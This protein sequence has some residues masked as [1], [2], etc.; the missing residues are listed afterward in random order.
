[1]NLS[2]LSYVFLAGIIALAIVDQW[3]DGTYAGFWR[4]AA[5]LLALSL[6]YEWAIQRNYRLTIM[7]DTEGMLRLGRKGTVNLHFKNLNRRPLRI[8]YVPLLP[9]AF[10]NSLEPR[11]ILLAPG[12]TVTEVIEI[13]PREL[14]VHSW[15]RLYMR[16]L[17]R[18]QLCWWSSPQDVDIPL[19]VVPDA[20][21]A[22]EKNQGTDTTGTSNTVVMGAGKELLLLREY[23]RGD[24]LH[25]VDWK[26]TARTGRHITRVFSEDQH[27]E[28]MLML[29]I[30]RSSRT[31]FDELDQFGHY[32]NVA[33]RFAERAVQQDDLVG[34]IALADT[35]QA[36]VP[37]RR[38]IDAVLQIRESLGRLSSQPVESDL[39][40]GAISLRTVTRRRC[41]IVLM[42][43]L[44]GQT[45]GSPLA[46]S[47]RLMAP[48]HFCVVASLL[49]A[50][51]KSLAEK[52][53]DEW[54]DPYHSLA[55]R[56]YIQEIHLNAKSLNRAGAH[57]LITQP[58]ELE[59]R[60]MN[61]YRLV[62]AQRRV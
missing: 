20:L 4:L 32:V 34:L 16:V 36:I 54:L 17:G 22:K 25:A 19:R 30:G 18:L 21:E 57:V 39:V 15:N 9:E 50:D 3:S 1:M 33:A 7:A 61:Y 13:F 27:L 48:K 44:Y 8:N 5:L 31:N 47:I 52:F 35:P 41:L 55:A 23:Q 29:D 60:V 12:E 26:A 43:N 45:K 40:A 14:G 62:K 6:V 28:V 58:R 42:T 51:M 24:P 49:G 2:Q 11:K 46:K 37:P 59:R 10:D 38:G 56:Q 53:S